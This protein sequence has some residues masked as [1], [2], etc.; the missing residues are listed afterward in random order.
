MKKIF[1]LFHG[2][3]PSEKA[4]ALYAAE[5]AKSLSVHVPI[6]LL[7]P[8]RLGREKDTAHVHYNLPASM[9]VV[10]LPTVDLFQTP[11][12]RIAFGVSYVAFSCAVFTYLLFTVKKSDIVDTNEALPA[13]VATFVSRRV[14]YEVHDF[15]ERF[16]WF[17]KILLRQV[18]RV[19]ATNEWKN[20]QLQKEFCLPAGKI[21]MERNGVNMEQF[22][23]G[24]RAQARRELG[25]AQDA[26]MAVYTGH[27]Y[28]WKGVETL[29][30][31]AALAPSIEVY[32]VG[33]TS[34]DVKQFKEKHGAVRNIHIVGQVP[35]AQVPLWLSAADVLVLPNTA[36]EEISA[37]YTSPMKLFEYMAAGRAI[38]AS[39]IPS[40]TEVLPEEGSFL[41]S[42]DDPEAMARAIRSACDNLA[43]AARRA[44][45][46]R[47]AVLEYAWDKRAERLALQFTP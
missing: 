21:I 28:G 45:Y 4:A 35:H 44:A 16:L 14:V 12:R 17:Y 26:R 24:D 1:I 13:L 27:L 18:W 31:A 33:G 46:A 32:F 43:E 7:V 47:A 20:I 38:V 19:L 40:I 34:E 30:Q 22:A 6:V 2:R 15:P 11:L 5:H 37:H 3:F 9:R 36:K 42:P 41:V 39:R 8:R 10:Y 29:A 25:L 23:P